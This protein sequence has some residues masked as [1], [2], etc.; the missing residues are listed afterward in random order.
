MATNLPFEGPDARP[1]LYV[2]VPFCL[3]KCP[4]CA[5]H[6][7]TDTGLLGEYAAALFSEMEKAAGA[8]AFRDFDTVYLGGGT[9]SLLPPGVVEAILSRAARLFGLHPGASVTLEANPGTVDRKRLAAFRAAGVNRVNFGVQ[10]FRDENLRFLGR[11]HSADEARRALSA[12]RDAG[13]TSPGLDLMYGLPGQDIDAWLSDLSEA[14]S[15]APGHISAYILSFEEG[16]RLSR[17]RDAGRLKPATEERQA[18]LFAAT[19]E[20]LAERG[21]LHYEVSNFAA[22]PGSISRH[23]TKYW[24]GAPYLG[25]GPSAHSYDGRSRWWNAELPGYLAAA[26]EGRL[27]VSGREEPSR[28][29]RIL[30]ALFLGLRQSSGIDPAAFTSAFGPRAFSILAPAFSRLADEGLLSL[31]DGRYRPT[32]SGMLVADGM[33]RHLAGI[34][35]EE[36]R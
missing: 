33:A 15:H 3:A 36:G 21:F 16:T 2:H 24:N 9:P 10:S 7:V 12:A 27:P 31:S 20:F 28:P 8:F 6:S 26:R 25:L 14:V 19:H 30:E 29:E 1:G 32:V 5:F 18:E 35:E 22:G 11:I 34:L 13:F 17:D 4:Y 23:N